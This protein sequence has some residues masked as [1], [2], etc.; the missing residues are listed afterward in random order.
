MTLI[1]MSVIVLAVLITMGILI[2]SLRSRARQA[3]HIIRELSRGNLKS[4][5]PVT[6]MD[7]VGQVMFSFN[8]MADEI[9][10]LIESLRK[11]EGTRKDLLRQL[12]HDLRTP[13]AS[14][15]N[16]IETVRDQ[17][18]ALSEQKRIELLDLSVREIDYFNGLVNDLLFLGSVQEPLYKSDVSRFDLIDLI[19]SEI[20]PIGNRYPKITVDF[21]SSEPSIEVQGDSALMKRLVRNALE[22]AY[23][24]AQAKIQIQVHQADKGITFKIKD[25]GP[26]FSPESLKDFGQRKF[27]RMMPVH[28]EK[29]ISIGLGSVIMRSIVEAFRGELK[30]QNVESGAQIEVFLPHL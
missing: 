1:Q 27:S 12:A 9:E 29:R 7:E 15:R 26:G 25:D 5:F 8:K 3:E 6:I 19:K 11:S 24:F 17:S 13:I 30:A 23:S 21:E 4:R 22:N 18:G 10:H 2:Y 14:L 28:G 16:M 20:A